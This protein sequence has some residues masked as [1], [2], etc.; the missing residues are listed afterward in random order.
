MTYQL[1]VAKMTPSCAT[2]SIKIK[3]PI[4]EENS[5]GCRMLYRDLKHFILQLVKL[6]KSTIQKLQGVPDS[7]DFFLLKYIK[8][9]RIAERQA[10]TSLATHKERKRKGEREEPSHTQRERGRKGGRETGKQKQQTFQKILSLNELSRRGL[11][12]IVKDTDPPSC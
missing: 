9:I 2:T 12:K 8:T 7:L 11:K 10:Q 4:L 6:R 1:Q 5:L 3:P